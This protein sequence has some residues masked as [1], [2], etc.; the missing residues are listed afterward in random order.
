MEVL[1]M[2]KDEIKYKLDVFKN[3]SKEN[4][5]HCSKSI[6][7]VRNLIDDHYVTLSQRPENVGEKFHKLAGC[8]AYCRLFHMNIS[9]LMQG[10]IV[11]YDAISLTIENYVNTNPFQKEYELEAACKFM[12]NLVDLIWRL[13]SCLMELTRLDPDTDFRKRENF[14][15]IMEVINGEESNFID[16]KKVIEKIH[17]Y[18]YRTS[19]AGDYMKF[20][21]NEKTSYTIKD[22]YI[23]VFDAIIF[24]VEFFRDIFSQRLFALTAEV[25]LQYFGSDAYMDPFAFFVTNS[26]FN[27]LC[28]SVFAEVEKVCESAK[29]VMPKCA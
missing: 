28:F 27:D 12:D 1:N 25:Q 7:K 19:Y 5:V 8:L 3:R 11:M 20:V 29:H 21:F 15:T 17:D 6:I 2:T 10:A 16:L 23:K 14:K 24:N 22:D 26:V 4:A 13:E 18:E 9:S